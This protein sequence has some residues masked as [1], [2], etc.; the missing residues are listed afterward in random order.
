M[1]RVMRSRRLSS[2]IPISKGMLVIIS[3]LIFLVLTKA[4]VDTLGV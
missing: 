3:L 2:V 1:K 4:E